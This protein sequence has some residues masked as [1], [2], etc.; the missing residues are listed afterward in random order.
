MYSTFSSNG[1]E[2]ASS[3]QNVPSS[4]PCFLINLLVKNASYFGKHET[5]EIYLELMEQYSPEDPIG[6]KVLTSALMKRAITDVDRIFRLRE[7]KPSLSNLIKQGAVGE[8]L[9]ERMLDAE[10]DLDLEV[11]EVCH[12]IIYFIWVFIR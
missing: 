9:W 4:S 2:A 5:K 10:R 12:L 3:K 6:K 7:E 11:Q 8:D 1:T